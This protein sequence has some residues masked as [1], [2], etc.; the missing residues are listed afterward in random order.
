MEQ[1][2]PTAGPNSQWRH[3]RDW[4][5]VVSSCRSVYFNG[6]ATGDES[7]A[8]RVAHGP[9]AYPDKTEENFDCLNS[10]LKTNNAAQFCTRILEELGRCTRW[11][12]RD[13][14]DAFGLCEL[15]YWISASSLGG[16]TWSPSIQT[17]LQQRALEFPQVRKA[18]LELPQ[19]GMCQSRIWKLAQAS[20]RGLCALPSLL[21]GLRR[22]ED[23][24]SDQH[25]T[26]HHDCNAQTCLMSDINATRVEQ[27]HVCQDQN[28]GII[29]CPGERLNSL[30]NSTTSGVWF[31]ADQHRRSN[32]RLI[33]KWLPTAPE[34]TPR[35][36][37]IGKGK[38]SVPYLAI[39][40]VWSDGTGA[41]L[42]P[43]GEVNK[44]L[45][46][47]WGHW[48]TELGC[49]A[50]WWDTVCVP[51]DRAQRQKALR[52]MHKNFSA[53][54]YTLIHDR[55]LVN[56]AW[57][58]DGSPCLA[59][60]MSTWFTR[61]WTALELYASD[62]VKV[63]FADQ[64]G[65]PILKDLHSE[66]LTKRYDGQD[67]F[68]HPAWVNLSKTIRELQTQEFYSSG[69]TPIAT[70]L[71]IL[72]PRSTSWAQDRILIASLIADLADK[73]ESQIKYRPRYKIEANQPGLF[74]AENTKTL[75]KRCGYI[76]QGCLMH[77]QVTIQASGPWSWCPLSVFDLSWPMFF[78]HKAQ[79]V[80]N[81]QFEG[82]LE[83]TWLSTP[84]Q[85]E[86]L[87]R[88]RPLENT[89]LTLLARIREAF[90]KVENHILLAASGRDYPAWRDRYLLVEVREGS[91]E[92]YYRRA[93]ADEWNDFEPRHLL[94]KCA[95]IG[96]VACE[97]DTVILS[98]MKLQHF[99]FV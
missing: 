86:D 5:L 54:K 78:E 34:K 69:S 15:L 50:I 58:E 97:R 26:I 61:G 36:G 18:V 19:Q 55:D 91:V 29:V 37:E 67:P 9:Q 76:E 47:Y 96:T 63:L 57:K 64:D 90:T 46:D 41:G 83:G 75:L 82:C 79:V 99:I 94:Q 65:H 27:L 77:G 60:A 33:W 35:F 49:E 70:I 16:R 88:L 20:R 98:R 6:S 2:A 52:R 73:Y 13:G 4:A 39:S 89:H 92:E 11:L 45:F 12:A 85:K 10:F 93:K 95:Y 23:G 66:V 32:A 17:L 51:T 24:L 25:S 72:N 53:A 71:G 68:A 74:Q 59:L 21:D 8:S 81:G 56:F 14:V 3:V 80:P 62:A 48:A 38:P 7:W 28:C 42:M 31:V 30:D 22:M 87:D 1:A 43:P 84:L 40:H 44:C